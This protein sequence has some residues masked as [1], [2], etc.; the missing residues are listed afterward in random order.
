MTDLNFAHLSDEQLA[1]ILTGEQVAL[2]RLLSLSLSNVPNSAVVYTPTRERVAVE[3][4]VLGL[5]D[6]V[7]EAT[8]PDRWAIT[9]RGLQVVRARTVIEAEARDTIPDAP[10]NLTVSALSDA[11]RAALSVDTLPSHVRYW[12]VEARRFVAVASADKLTAQVRR[13]ALGK[14]RQLVRV[15]ADAANEVERKRTAGEGP[16][17]E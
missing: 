3:L 13:D 11:D 16:R 6:E 17:A 7:D 8:S 9:Q 14:L 5:V 15:V 2:L 10:V 1:R 4:N 12:M